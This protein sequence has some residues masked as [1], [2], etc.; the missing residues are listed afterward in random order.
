M[1]H[2][3]GERLHH[4]RDTTVAMAQAMGNEAREVVSEAKGVVA[5]GVE[6]ARGAVKRGAGR[7]HD[8]VERTKAAT[9]LA[10]DRAVTKVD[11]KLLQ[12]SGV[13]QALAERYD[14]ALREKRLQRSVEEV[15]RERY[16]PIDERDNSHLRGV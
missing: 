9:H 12:V 3:A 11:A 15:L 16:R 10:E 14:S 2:A 5:A 6:G 7:A 1:G 4:A 8:L 13:E